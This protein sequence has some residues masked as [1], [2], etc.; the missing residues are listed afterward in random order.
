MDTKT[1]A[2]HAW[3]LFGAAA[4]ACALFA[5]NVAAADDHDVT[6][7]IHVNTHGLDLN[8]PADAQTLYTRLQQAAWVAS[9][10]GDRVDLLPPE[11]PTACYQKALGSAVRSVNAPMLTQRYLETHTLREA[12]A[13]GIAVPAQIATVGQTTTDIPGVPIKNV[14]LSYGVSTAELDLSTQSGRQ[15]LQQRVSNAAKAACKELGRQF[16]EATPSDLDCVK[17]ATN[18]A[19]VQVQ[20]LVA[21]ATKK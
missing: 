19:M 13:H 3:S 21:A 10:R 6:V 20:Q 7:A 2:L 5:G 14:S 8:Q 9:T 17:A 1:N 18:K 15:E 4:A 12:A 16:P 11:N